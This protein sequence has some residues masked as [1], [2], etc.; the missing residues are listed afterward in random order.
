MRTQINNGTIMCSGKPSAALF[1]NFSWRIILPTTSPSLPQV[2]KEKVYILRQHQVTF[3]D[4]YLGRGS[5]QMI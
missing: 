1:Y 4:T 3:R 5:E 2:N